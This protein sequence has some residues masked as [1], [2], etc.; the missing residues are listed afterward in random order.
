M[1]A[2][3]TAPLADDGKEWKTKLILPDK[4]RRKKTADVATLRGSEWEDICLQR[5]LL[6]G[7]FE[8]GMSLC[9]RARVMV[10]VVDGRVF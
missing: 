8:K 1:S 4:D 2:T 7:I 5:E 9:V 10:I 6:M 3:K